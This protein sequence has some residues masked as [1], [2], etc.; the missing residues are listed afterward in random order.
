[1]DVEANG[2]GGPSS[3]QHAEGSQGNNQQQLPGGAK[4]KELQND[5]NQ[6]TSVMQSNINKVLERGDRMDTLNERSEL[7]SSRANEF[8][9][10][11]RNVS[12]KFWWQNFRFQLTIGV[13]V[14]TL[15][16]VV[17]YLISK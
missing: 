13:V 17:I 1:M 9:I 3:Y 11:S 14:L 15:I 2:S 5:V 8:R 16:I 7:L 10:N 6:L 12:R 4:I